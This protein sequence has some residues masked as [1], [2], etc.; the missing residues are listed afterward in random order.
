LQ[1]APVSEL[2]TDYTPAYIRLARLLREQ[3]EDGTYP[4]GTLLPSSKRL[5]AAHAVSTATALRARNARGWRLR[6]ARRVQAPSSH[7]AEIGPSATR[8]SAPIW[9]R[10]S[11][12]LVGALTSRYVARAKAC[13]HVVHASDPARLGVLADHVVGLPPRDVHEVIRR[14]ARRESAV[15]ERPAETMR[16]DVLNPCLLAPAPDHV[17]DARVRHPRGVVGLARLPPL[18]RMRSRH[19]VRYTHRSHPRRQRRANGGL[20]ISRFTFNRS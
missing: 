20:R 4:L 17:A 10:L 11:W 18:R 2:D 13:V 1:A 6:A 7:L 16:V 9:G 3:I 15:G 8:E 14:P 12:C 19:C 5:A